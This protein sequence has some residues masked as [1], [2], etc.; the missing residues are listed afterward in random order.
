MILAKT[1]HGVLY[2]KHLQQIGLQVISLWSDTQIPKRFYFPLYKLTDSNLGTY[3]FYQ[4]KEK[5][6][7]HQYHESFML[8]I[9]HEFLSSV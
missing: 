2:F 5:D 7:T 3:F 4:I 6:S 1:A 8:K 9:S